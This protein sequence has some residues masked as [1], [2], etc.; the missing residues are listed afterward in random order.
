MVST[1][2]ILD[3]S[4][5]LTETHRIQ[6]DTWLAWVRQ[7]VSKILHHNPNLGLWCKIHCIRSNVSTALV[8]ILAW[9]A[10]SKKDY[11]LHLTVRIE[12]SVEQPKEADKEEKTIYQLTILYLKQK[13]HLKDIK[14]HGQLGQLGSRGT[15]PRLIAYF[16]NQ[17][18]LTSNT[19]EEILI[20][21]VKRSRR[22]L[23]NPLQNH[24]ALWSNNILSFCYQSI[25]SIV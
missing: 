1:L 12:S 5:L 17:L 18:E 11:I 7:L 23:N 3:S 24:I 16:L 13:Y 8:D 9:N 15:K 6:S 19:L 20:T 25:L 14:V 4:I 10:T 21:T 2:S 22:I